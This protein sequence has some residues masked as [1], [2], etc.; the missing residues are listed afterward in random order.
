[1]IDFEFLNIKGIKIYEM[2]S[3]GIDDS[4]DRFDKITDKFHRQI[5]KKTKTK[6]QKQN[7]FNY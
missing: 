3:S 5:I 7:K 2:Y 6:K 4:K 1:M